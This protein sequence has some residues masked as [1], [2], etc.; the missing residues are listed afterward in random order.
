MEDKKEKLPSTSTQCD[1]GILWKMHSNYWKYWNFNVEIFTSL[2]KYK[3]KWGLEY[4]YK[5][6]KRWL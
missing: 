4:G 3:R 5:I 2:I 1:T 6:W